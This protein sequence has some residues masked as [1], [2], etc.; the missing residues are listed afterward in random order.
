MR[1]GRAVVVPIVAV[2][3]AG[4][5]APA[6]LSWE[7]RAVALTLPPN[8][9]RIVDVVLRAR[10]AVAA[11]ELAPT[12]ELRPYV[13]TI[14][15]TLSTLI[16]GA[17]RSVRL[18]INLPVA[19]RV[20]DRIT[21]RLQPT[22][23]QG[24]VAELLPIDVQVAP[25][26]PEHT[27]ENLRAALENGDESNYLRQFIPQRR[28][29]Q[30]ATFGGLTDTARFALAETLRTAERISLSDDGAT[31]EYRIYLLLGK[32]RS[33]SSIELQRSADGIWRVARF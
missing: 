14:P 25:S 2:L 16:G 19:V 17:T 30:R 20:G 26:T 3:A 12:S 32:Q 10:T 7:P 6:S 29:Q 27:L 11:L 33:E 1:L 24:P 15:R 28:P 9:Y 31:A 13:D 22:G 8:A 4:C 23:A 21:G 5:V 18:V